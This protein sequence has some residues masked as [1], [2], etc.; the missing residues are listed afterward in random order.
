MIQRRGWVYFEELPNHPDGAP[1]TWHADRDGRIVLERVRL[2]DGKDAWLFSKNTVRNLDK[3]YQAA[4]AKEPDMHYV[5]LGR[6]APAPTAEATSS[7]TS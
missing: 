3:M 7:P 1:Y 5:Q 6:V 2:P 4:R